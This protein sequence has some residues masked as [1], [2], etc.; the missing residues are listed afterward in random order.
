MILLKPVGVIFQ[1]IV[2]KIDY[3]A[4]AGHSL[5]GL[6]LF[7]KSASSV[8]VVWNVQNIFYY[9][10][11]IISGVSIQASLFVIFSSITFWTFK[12]RNMIDFIFFNTR[13]F[14]GYPISIYPT[15]IQNLLIFIVPF[16]FI[17]YFPAQYLL[18]KPDLS[19]Y[20]VGYLY[21]TPIIAVIFVLIAYQF[22]NLGLRHY[23]ST[24]N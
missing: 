3:F 22:W 10:I 5:L 13:R 8:G 16:T 12:L 6:I 17:N 24:G 21:M 14:A 2:T 23:S 7:I 19:S 18:R 20:W 1:V 11:V 15:I 9:I 4:S